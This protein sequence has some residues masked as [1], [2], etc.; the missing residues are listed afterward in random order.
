MR[1]FDSGPRLQDFC[2]T[3]PFTA[4]YET[5]LGRPQSGKT[6]EEPPI[7]RQGRTKVVGARA[8]RRFAK[9]ESPDH[10]M[11]VKS[12]VPL[13]SLRNPVRHH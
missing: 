1:R 10:G 4:I 8:K 7:G 13:D 9:R 5:Y 12:R 11:G 2:V 3:H 6:R